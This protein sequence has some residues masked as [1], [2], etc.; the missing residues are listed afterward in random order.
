MPA[1][2]GERRNS[3]G[4]KGLASVL[5]A[6]FKGRAAAALLLLLPA[7]AAF[8]LP[9]YAAPQPISGADSTDWPASRKVFYSEGYKRTWVFY[10]NAKGFASRSFNGAT[11]SAEEVAISTIEA[12]G[13][14][15]LMYG[16]VYYVATDS[17]VYAVANDPSADTDPTNPPPANNIFLKK[18]TLNAD[19][20]ITWGGLQTRPI[21]GNVDGRTPSDCYAGGNV[22]IALIG[23]MTTGAVAWVCD[24][25]RRGGTQTSVLGQPDVGLNLVGGTVI[26]VDQNDRTSEGAGP[27]KQ[28]GTIVPVNDGGT[29]KVIEAQVDRSDR[30]GSLRIHR[31]NG[32]TYEA[33][34][35]S[36]A[37]GTGGNDP[38]YAPSMASEPNASVVHLAFIDNTGS[39]VYMRRTAAGTWGV[40]PLAIDN[41]GAAFATPYGQPSVVYAAKDAA[42]AASYNKV[43][44]IYLSTYGS[45]N[46]AVGP[47]TATAAGEFSITR[48]W[49]QSAGGAT[50][51]QAP[52]YI[53]LPYPVPVA[54]T[55][56]GVVEFD[57]LPTSNNAPPGVTSA[58]PA[59]VG[60]GAGLVDYATDPTYDI[61]FTGTGFLNNPAPG[62]MF[63]RNGSA[64]AGVAITSVTYNSAT[65]I[66]AHFTVDQSVAG[67]P[68]DAFISNWDGRDGFKA[69]VATV[70]VPSSDLTYPVE[71]ILYSSGIAQI[72][73]VSGLSPA[74]GQS[75]IAPEMRI[76]RS[77]GYQ[78]NSVNYVDP[79]I[80]GQQWLQVTSGIT[81]WSNGGW[82]NDAA[83]Q[84]DGATYTLESR[85]KTSDRGFG[86]PSSAVTFKIDKSPPGV[87]FTMPV[88]NSSNSSLLSIQGTAADAGVGLQSVQM[89]LINSGPNGTI[90]EAVGNDDTYWTGFDATGFQVPATWYYVV[91]LPSPPGTLTNYSC[92]DECLN[93]SLNFIV[94]AVPDNV[95]H[96]KLPAWIDGRKYRIQARASDKFNPQTVGLS[97]DFYYDVTAPT[98]TVTVPEALMPNAPVSQGDP[99]NV[100]RN[101]FDF[102]QGSLLDNVVDNV[103]GT[104]RVYYCVY[105]QGGADKWGSGCASPSPIYQYAQYAP[106]SDP[107]PFSIGVSTD[108]KNGFWYDVAVYAA[109][110]ANNSTGTALSPA[111]SGYFLYDSEI[112][113]LGI[114]FPVSGGNYGLNSL[115]RL[116]GTA[117]DGFSKVSKTEYTLSHPP[118][119]KWDK[120]SSLWLDQTNDIWNVGGTTTTVPYDVWQSSNIAWL[121]GEQ[122]TYVGRALDKAGNYSTVYSTVVFRYDATPPATAVLNPL[123][124]ATYSDTALTNISGTAND[125]P[126][127]TRQSG[128][129][130]TCIGVQRQSDGLWW[131]GTV[132]GWQASRNDSCQSPAASWNHQSM[133]GFWTGVPTADEFKVYA[134]S[135]DN[136][137]LPDGT[138]R[139]VESST[140]LKKTFK[141]EVQ[142]PTSTI[143]SPSD[144]SWYSNNAGY[145][146]S[147]IVG[148]AVDLPLTGLASG[149]LV[150]GMQAEVRDEVTLTCWN[151]TDFSGACG[152][153]AT[154]KDM[155]LVADSTYTY[156]TSTLFAAA[157]DG[158]PYRVRVRAADSALDKDN[159][160]KSNVESVFSQGRNQNTFRPDRTP[161]TTLIQSPATADV[162][163]FSSLS[164]TAADTYTGVK[165][166]QVAYYS[167]TA[168]KWWNPATVGTF[169][170][171]DGINPPPELAYVE[172]STSTATPVPWTV[173]GSSVP[174]L[175]NGQ[176]YLVFA[177]AT[178]L[179]DNKTAWPGYAGF[180]T[181]PAQSS[182]IKINKVT[183]LPDS[184]ISVPPSGVPYYRPTDLAV[185]SGTLQAADTVQV[186]IT[187]LSV[188]PNQVWTPGGW[189]STVTYLAGCTDSTYV[190]G[191]STC[192]YFG[193]DSIAAP[194]WSRA[195]AGI[196]PAGTAY[197]SVKSRAAS[198]IDGIP[199]LTPLPERYFYIDGD[200]PATTLA[201]PNAQYERSVPSI[202]GL[203]SD[204][205]VGKVVNV[206]VDISTMSGTYYWTGSSWT[207][208]GAVWLPAVPDDGFFD[209]NS[210]GWHLNTGLPAFENSKTYEVQVRI[211]DKAGR[212]KYFPTPYQ[213]FTIDTASP[214]ARILLP[215]GLQGVN[216]IAELS[217]TAA[218]NG[219]N[220]SVQVAIQQWG[221]PQLWY[222]GTGF[223]ALQSN[224][225]WLYVGGA[226]GF[227]SPN[228]TSWAYAPA[229]LDSASPG[230]LKYLLLTRS[231]DVAGNLQDQFVVD[232]S[233]RVVFV[234]KAPPATSVTLP[235]DDSNGLSGRYKSAN[236]GKTATSSRFYGSASDSFYAANNAGVEKT[237][238]RLSYLLSGD[239]WYW[240]GTSFS[241]G[242]AALSASWVNASGVGSWIYP[243]DITWP[244]GDREYALEARSMDATR[245]WDGIGQGNWETVLSQGQNLMKF[246][247]CDT[248]PDVAITTPTELSLTSDTNIY[249]TANGNLAGFNKAQV[250]IS[251]GTGA[252]I[253]YWDGLASSWVAAPE[254]WN[255]SI[256]MGPTSWY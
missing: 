171:G 5:A 158:R 199:E 114:T 146:L 145:Q 225:Y 236:I 81:T 65:Q 173:T 166:V 213:Q 233:S 208:S 97:R 156:N 200:D 33:R 10:E 82:P 237:L 187:D 15:N 62:V 105:E 72:T 244:A 188:T 165:R 36:T 53:Q 138:F 127:T 38:Y 184:T 221:S 220:E 51:P 28:F 134:W 16:S 110:A 218:D 175:V 27:Y 55:A 95:A 154:W 37:P 243:N 191:K 90:G 58:S 206:E 88:P 179:V 52:S 132:N 21:T 91:Q 24:A 44:I 241:S 192:G 59:T 157:V 23:N 149:G 177:R 112:P 87:N 14:V 223:N 122:Y 136:V 162:Y 172:A 163:V 151:G 174:A 167:L 139:N 106:A 186:M 83:A 153:A 181:P 141:Y 189:I 226:N 185:I 202:Y 193:V 150:S 254:T 46:Y 40:G 80:S 11:W 205:G 209:S 183:P 142:P 120:A 45:V 201:E 255:D 251:T 148:S 250:R 115:V 47:A 12:G 48:D 102:L 76:T 73:G 117:N 214:T 217:G 17:V 104:R 109:D 224:P 77:D 67:G 238:I 43:Y 190:I 133:G 71:P 69:G 232:V 75:N 56:G 54:W 31:Y 159:I 18:G 137:D 79:A 195:T 107:Y 161:P 63:S 42:D 118:L 204:V 100:W 50:S 253:K 242:T 49:Q 194:N 32:T 94:K 3:A 147:A 182:L 29:W 135:K 178:D 130:M 84:A 230:G 68:M 210:E 86:N 1:I 113:T 64:V 144:N 34:E 164:G 108:W 8:R 212:Q 4:L 143:L 78:W 111:T 180:T 22:S 125:M 169:S 227:L 248:P 124:G 216:I 245:P 13:S 7:L 60:I 228:A 20:S 66:Q 246:V 249:G 61:T 92:G 129:N 98:I 215:D 57:R 155:A 160:L 170:L 74:A 39:L 240:I 140:T 222:D 9:G 99:A 176:S 85:G 89:Q 26:S 229:G 119:A 234:D 197:F 203:A 219:R 123:T 101:S 131:N 247:I 198:D 19:G 25:K 30:P 239:T 70:T 128:L 231:T 168:Q 152:G 126:D 2:A 256:R 35:W 116:L 103:I 207:A 252:A 93:K 121:S 196:W 211:T 235:A 41:L 96:S 6:R